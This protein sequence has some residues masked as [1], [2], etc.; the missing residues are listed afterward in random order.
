MKTFPKADSHKLRESNRALVLQI[1][2]EG[3]A[4]TRSELARRS[5]LAKPTVSTIVEALVAEGVVHELG[6]GPVRSK[7]GPRGRLVGLNPDAAAFLGIH[8]GVKGTSLALAD[9]RGEIRTTAVM[10]SFRE[11]PSAALREVL[12]AAL[13]L[14]RST[15]TPPERL[16]GVGVA[17]PGLVQHET[18]TCVFAPNLGWTNVPLGDA[19]TGLFHVGTTVRNS[20]QAAAV[21]EACVGVGKNVHAFVWLYIGSGV[22]AALVI[23]GQVFYGKRGYTGELGHWPVVPE[24]AVCAC[25]RRGC[26]ETVAS[27]EAVEAVASARWSEHHRHRPPHRLDALTVAAAAQNGEPFARA[28]LDE[29]GEHLGAAV[30]SLLNLLDPDLIVLDGGLIR[31]GS[32]L[33]EVVRRSAKRLAIGGGAA[34]IVPSSVDD[35]AMLRGAVFLAMGRGS[36]DRFVVEG[37]GHLK[38]GGLSRARS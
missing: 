29:V 38:L 30:A 24:G 1:L 10:A 17:V 12:P 36:V 37:C 4:V 31:T 35:D 20:M 22:G 5:S 21:A 15:S 8:Y 7:A 14:C 6:S 18:G 27:N 33:L 32:Y 23:D 9:A 26:L 11:D 2:G 13:E 25:G 19:L 28:A 34:P 3:K 16:R